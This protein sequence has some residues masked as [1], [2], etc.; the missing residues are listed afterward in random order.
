M[1]DTSN[2]PEEKTLSKP[3]FFTEENLIGLSIGT[4]TVIFYSNAISMKR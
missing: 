4:A 3:V 2:H 1:N